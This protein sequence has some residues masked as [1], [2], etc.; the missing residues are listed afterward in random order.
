M[1]VPCAVETK[2]MVILDDKN[3]MLMNNGDNTKEQSSSFS[4][5]SSLEGTHEDD[6]NCSSSTP[7]L[8]PCSLGLGCS[9]VDTECSESIS[10]PSDFGKYRLKGEKNSSS[11]PSFTSLRLNYLLVN[12]V[13]MLADGM[14]GA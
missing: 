4:V 12:L 3:E 7:I 6:Y 11:P 14:Q 2:T 9:L 10:S 5:A 13:I 1:K 8:L